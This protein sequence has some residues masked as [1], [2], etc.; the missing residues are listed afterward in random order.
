M[1]IALLNQVYDE[2]RRL[3][4]AGSSV[5]SGDFRLKKLIPA[6]EQAGAKSAVFAKLAQTTKALVE[7]T[8]STASTALLELGTFINSILYTQG[9]TGIEGEWKPID[10]IDLGLS[11]TQTSARL[12]K[13]LLEALTNKGSGR[14]EIIRSAHQQGLFQDLRLVRPA[15][16]ALDDS[17]SEIADFVADEILPLYGPALVPEL[18]AQFN[19]N[20][21]RGHARRLL[22]MHKL[23]P[24]LSRVHVRVALDQGD[25]EMRVA[26]IECLGNSP[27]DLPFLLDQRKARAKEVRRAAMISL[28]RMNVES[29]ER[30]LIQEIDGKDLDLA[31]EALRTSQSAAVLA[32]LLDRTRSQLNDLITSKSKTKT[33]GTSDKRIERFIQLLAC[34][35][36]RADAQVESLHL[37][38]LKE[39]DPIRSL[40]GIPSGD[41]ILHT[42]ATNLASGSPV[43]KQALGKAHSA[44]GP[45]EMTS[46]FDAANEVWKPDAVFKEFSPYLVA[47]A[48]SGKK[49]G[50]DAQRGEAIATAL[51]NSP[52]NR[53]LSHR[54]ASFNFDNL[55]KKWLELSIQLELDDLITNLATLDKKLAQSALQNLFAKKIEAKTNSQDFWYLD[56]VLESMVA[57]EHPALVDSVIE[58]IKKLSTS[59]S[60]NGTWIL[61]H[62]ALLP[63]QE[64]LP[65]LEALLP[66]LSGKIANSVIESVIA[67]KQTRS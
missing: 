37:E 41:D 15:L 8:E 40:K 54:H 34:L 22:L 59:P 20:G 62:V 47:F 2:S 14:F 36:G 18:E 26:A 3:A 11:K 39:I 5:A 7:S 64:A 67:L 42:L 66:T 19:P 38:I 1:S 27:E 52:S 17:Y 33:K 10:S 25:A 30:A 50:P 6:L 58:A 65:K 32:T 63:P 53:F 43:M 29:A 57:V 35:K 48:K 51:S 31:R 16:L 61:R 56:R 46:I 24:E 13:P 21:G 55:S 4:I 44:F 28:S 23:A 9:E 45:A 12:L 60:H 49:K